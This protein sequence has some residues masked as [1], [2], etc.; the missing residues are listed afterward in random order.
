MRPQKRIAT[1]R[2]DSSLA[3][4]MRMPF[5]IVGLRIENPP[6]CAD[7]EREEAPACPASSVF[8]IAAS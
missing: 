3:E 2:R 7:E 4:P 1:L 6:V 5:A 8:A